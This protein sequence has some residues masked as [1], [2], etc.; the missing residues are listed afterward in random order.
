MRHR[1]RPQLRGRPHHHQSPRPRCG[2]PRKLNPHQ[3]QEA[4]KRIE[5]G[6]T[7]MAIALAELVALT[8]VLTLIGR[9]LS[10]RATRERVLAD[11][12]GM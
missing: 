9:N 1:H 2:R 3:R 7:Y 12:V 8:G 6:E 5:A 11:A 4:L 10:E